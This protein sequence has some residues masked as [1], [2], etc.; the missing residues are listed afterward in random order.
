MRTH[1][2]FNRGGGFREL[3]SDLSDDNER[4]IGDN[5]VF[6][7]ISS[8]V[9]DAGNHLHRKSLLKLVKIYNGIT[10]Q[11]PL[12]LI[13]E[14]SGRKSRPQSERRNIPV[15]RNAI[16]ICFNEHGQMA[17]GKTAFEKDLVRNLTDHQSPF[18]TLVEHI[19]ITAKGKSRI[20]QFDKK[21][22][23]IIFSGNVPRAGRGWSGD[24]MVADYE[25]LQ[26]SESPEN[27]VKRLQKPRSIRKM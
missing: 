1:K 5:V 17:D 27:H 26:E 24:L 16:V 15:R 11:A 8:S 2:S 19:P 25:D 18:G 7:K 23:R 22:Q 21:T 14:R 10:T 13:N 3:D 20:H 12:V 4:N 6:T 9:T